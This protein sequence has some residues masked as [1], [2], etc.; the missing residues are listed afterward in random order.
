MVFAF[1]EI[2]QFYLQTTMMSFQYLPLYSM[3]GLNGVF[4]ILSSALRSESLQR[5]RGK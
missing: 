1:L 5:Q 3:A 4:Q 2:K